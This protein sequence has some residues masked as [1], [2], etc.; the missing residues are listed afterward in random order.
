MLRVGDLVQVEEH[1]NA[2]LPVQVLAIVLDPGGDHL[3]GAAGGA[4]VYGNGR[5]FRCY[6]YAIRRGG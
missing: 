6:R 5:V 4:E 3:P 1:T 2:G